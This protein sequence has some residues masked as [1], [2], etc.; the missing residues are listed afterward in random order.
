LK[1]EGDGAKVAQNDKPLES[2]DRRELL[3]LVKRLLQRGEEQDRRIA[4]LQRQLEEA[5]RAAKRQAAP[6][7]KGPPKT[8]P[9]R[10]GR[11]PGADY[12]PKRHRPP[13]SEIDEH[14]DAPLPPSCPDCRGAVEEIDTAFQDQIEI[15]RRSIHRRFTVHIGCCT[16]CG[17]RIQG[18]HP[19]Q[20][21][22]ALGAAASQLGP[23]A[24]AL[25]AQLNKEF[26]LPYGKIR[27][28]LR[29]AFGISVSRGGA[30]Q[31]VLRVAERLDP[32]YQQ[33]FA[34]VRRSR[35]VYPDETGWKIA[36]RLRWLWTFV[37]RTATAYVIR[38]SRGAEVVSEV[39]GDFYRGV[40]GHD[41]WA[42]YDQFILA[43]HQ[44]CLA[45]LFRRCEELL[46][47]ATR[48][49]VRFPRDLKALLKAAL[50]LR[51]RRDAGEVSAR[52]LAVAIGRLESRLTELLSRRFFNDENLRLAKHVNNHADQLFTFLRRPGVEATN[53]PAE[54]AIR[55][56]VVNRKVWGGNRTDAGA[57]AQEI[58]TSV[59]RTLH[60]RHADA[61]T[62]INH[63]LRTPPDRSAP[64]LPAFASR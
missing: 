52:G 62:F 58:L 59:L 9:K 19:L 37:T 7:S 5:R 21:S 31:V 32:A 26:G 54:Q 57:G 25:T 11:K 45:H 38:A 49:A 64:E 28:V 35:V 17:R 10:P 50:D 23:D 43:D 60:Q 29:A 47:T 27:S 41:G 33:I 40:M 14:L 13:L 8:D 20:T 3:D 34:I 63:V 39:L 22:D 1:A 30:A 6:F 24:Q 56:A 53:W 15:Q 42:P 18:R 16:D 4:E 51:D 2:L 48:G 12:G 36:G 61:M 46:S 44:Q 55:P